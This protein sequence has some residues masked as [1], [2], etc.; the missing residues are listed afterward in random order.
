M[1]K[2]S[3]TKVLAIGFLLVLASF[4]LMASGSIAVSVGQLPNF[5]GV[6]PGKFSDVQFYIVQGQNLTQPLHISAEGEFKVSL[7][8]SDG[9]ATSLTINTSGGNVANTRVFVRFFPGTIGVKNGTISHSSGQ[10]T[11]RNVTVSGSGIESTIPAGYYSTASGFGS[12]LKTQLQNIINNHTVYDYSGL[13]AIYQETDATFAGKV[14]DIYSDK[15]CQE[16]PY[17]FTFGVD[18]DTGSGGTTE[19]DKYNREHSFPQSWYG[20]SS[21]H[22]MRSD[23][24]HVYPVDKLVN[25]KRGNF[26]YGMVNNPTWTSQN[27]GKLG[28]NSISGYSGTAFE[29]IDAYKGDIARGFLYVVTR[30]Q[31]EISNWP[32]T[33]SEGVHMLDFQTFPGFRPWALNMLRQW[34]QN[35]PVSQKEILRNNAI[36][37]YQGN[38]NPFIDHPEFVEMIWNPTA[39]INDLMFAEVDVFPNPATNWFVVNTTLPEF[40]LRVFSSCGR[41]VMEIVSAQNEV[42]ISLTG[43]EPGVYFLIIRGNNE[44]HRTRLVVLK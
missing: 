15:P 29:P 33:G 38:R 37:S 27:G 7:N 39:S 26:P 30:Y 5:R 20:G 16:P 2:G 11:V 9:F 24:F 36:Y 34:H 19:G 43:I 10:A 12:E 14:W 31:D 41:V 21:T 35:D 40:E 13:W 42:P 25:S 18:Q 32:S 4:Q 1:I 6:Y 8:C 28:P 17:L 44:I 22:P 3:I 23:L